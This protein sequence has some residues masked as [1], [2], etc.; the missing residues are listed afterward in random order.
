MSFVFA[1]DRRNYSKSIQRSDFHWKPLKIILGGQRISV[2]W[3]LWPSAMPTIMHKM[4]KRRWRFKHLSSLHFH[5][6]LSGPSLTNDRERRKKY[7][8]NASVCGM[9]IWRH[10]EKHKL[11][12]S[13]EKTPFGTKC[14]WQ[15]RWPRTRLCERVLFEHKTGVNLTKTNVSPVVSELALYSRKKCRMLDKSTPNAPHT[16]FLCSSV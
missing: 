3:I 8:L 15:G 2:R 5:T 16:L 6:N 10:S 9:F 7:T 12:G 4:R 13:V 1:H 14:T 11:F